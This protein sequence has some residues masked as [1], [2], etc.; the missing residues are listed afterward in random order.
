[1]V[2]LAIPQHVIELI[3]RFDCNRDAYCSGEY[4][5]TE[6]RREFIDPLFKALGWDI[7]NEQGY[8]EGYK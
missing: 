6:T 2:K 3:E 4:N 7:D 8:A 5:E 1:M